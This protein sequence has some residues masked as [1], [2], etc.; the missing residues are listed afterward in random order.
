MSAQQTL[1]NWCQEN[2]RGYESVRC[3]D[4]SS[5][6][7]DGRVLCAILNR[8]R[9]DKISFTESFQRS[10]IDNLRA[11]F[12]VAEA[13]FG[14]PRI[15]E[16]E[17]NWHRFSLLNNPTTTTTK[18]RSLI[19]SRLDIDVEYPDE[20]SIM[21]YVSMLFNAMPNIP[22]H[23]SEIKLESVISTKIFLL[24]KIRVIYN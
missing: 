23:P 22:P 8:H 11:G 14:I 24:A 2:L 20:K 17:G 5:S 18:R 10:N 12:E 3:K 4:F 6:W 13:E 21:T 1:L 15:I 9:P 7:R 19:A 16:P